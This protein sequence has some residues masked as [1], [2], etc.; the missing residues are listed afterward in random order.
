MKIIN[1][2]TDLRGKL[3]PVYF[4]YNRE[5]NPQPA[6]LWIDLEKRTVEAD[7]S[8]EI[9]QGGTP[10]RVWNGTVRR[11]PITP[12]VKGDALAAL[13]ESKELRDYVQRMIDGF[14]LVWDGSNW[15][16][17]LTPDAEKAEHDLDRHCQVH[18]DPNDQATVYTAGEWLE[19]ATHE[20][21]DAA[22][23]EIDGLGTITADTPDAEL[24][25]MA[26]KLRKETEDEGIYLEP[27]VI[28]HLQEL[29]TR[30]VQMRDELNADD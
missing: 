22:R 17:K 27:R 2:L 30:C 19:A 15:L 25:A 13:L 4:R 20:D 7:Y 10:L 14:E 11:I 3:A 1:D 6:Y 12:Y 28:D 18:V 5:I 9:G 26:T 23:I 16:G 29:R 24:E 21:E 8:G